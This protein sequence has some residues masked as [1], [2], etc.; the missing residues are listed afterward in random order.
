MFLHTD[1]ASFS[2]L[3]ADYLDGKSLAHSFRLINKYVQ[4]DPDHL[5]LRQDPYL[6][7]RLH[8]FSHL[9]QTIKGL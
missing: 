9:E 3:A 6:F 7:S 2:L 5:G 8:P 1:R 4:Y